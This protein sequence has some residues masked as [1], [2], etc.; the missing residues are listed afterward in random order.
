[1]EIKNNDQP[2]LPRITV[3]YSSFS[4]LKTLQY[5]LLISVI[6]YLGRSLFIPL[7]FSLLISFILYPLCQWFEKRKLSR[8]FSIFLSICILLIFFL[9]I[10]GLLFHQMLTFFSEW[11]S[12]KIKLLQALTDLSNY[13]NE[14]FNITKIE[15]EHWLKDLTESSSMNVISFFKNTIYSSSIFIVFAL[16]IPIFSS[17][18]LYYRNML[19]N[20]LYSFFPENKKEIIHKV[21]HLTVH[22]YYDFIKG[23]AL[24]YIIVGTLNSVGLFL[25]GIPHP[26]LFGFVVSILTFIPYVGIIVGALLPIAVAWITY[27]SVWY[28]IS[29]I[30]LFTFIQYLEANVIFPMAVSSRLNLNTLVTLIA[31]IG[32]GIIW[33][34]AGMILFIPIIAIIKLIADN[35]N[36]LKSVSMLLGTSNK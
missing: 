26:I 24:V 34:A 29:V 35:T 18:I 7:S 36:E 14:Q 21:L 5:T 27:N 22:T 15:Q 3:G 11:P 2:P 19:T 10:L 17:L 8:P 6:L 16:L 13:I 9:G 32:G 20:V 33:G 25:I 4:L 30:A 31:I 1:M 23:M 12:L 28:P